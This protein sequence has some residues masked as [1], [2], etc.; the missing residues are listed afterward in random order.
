MYQLTREIHTPLFT[1][2]VRFLLLLHSTSQWVTYRCARLSIWPRDIYRGFEKQ[3]QSSF[4]VIIVRAVGWTLTYL[5]VQNASLIDRPFMCTWTYFIIQM[6]HNWCVLPTVHSW[7]FSVWWSFDEGMIRSTLSIH[8]VRNEHTKR[9]PQVENEYSRACKD[10]G[11]A[12]TLHPDKWLPTADELDTM[13]E[14]SEPSEDDERKFRAAWKRLRHTQR[15][16]TENSFNTCYW[17]IF[18]AHGEGLHPASQGQ[19]GKLCTGNTTCRM[20]CE[21]PCDN[22]PVVKALLI[23]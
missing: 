10:A 11:K 21:R 8:L 4:Y 17:I 20:L 22:V 2:P 7:L 12:A 18:V 1:H 14:I 6:I 13:I 5:T 15:H 9:D 3:H 16:Y 19:T 23:C